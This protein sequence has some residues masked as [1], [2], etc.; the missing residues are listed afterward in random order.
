MTI[1]IFTYT[2]DI[3]QELDARGYKVTPE[4]VAAVHDALLN[5]FNYEMANHFIDTIEAHGIELTEEE[6]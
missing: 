6:N 4:I 3:T 5:S 2:V 1:D